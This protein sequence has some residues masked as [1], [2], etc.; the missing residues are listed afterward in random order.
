MPQNIMKTVYIVLLV[1][2][3]AVGVPT[4]APRALSCCLPASPSVEQTNLHGVNGT[5]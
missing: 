4:G 1:V 3:L 2:V 5:A